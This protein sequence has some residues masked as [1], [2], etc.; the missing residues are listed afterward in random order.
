MAINKFIIDAVT[1]QL[2]ILNEEKESLDSSIAEYEKRLSEMK[3]RAAEYEITVN[4][5][6]EFLKEK[7]AIKNVK[8][9][10][11]KKR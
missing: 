10:S 8:A 5:T 9:A 7:K 2:L 1:E 3:K 4:E 6:L 11:P